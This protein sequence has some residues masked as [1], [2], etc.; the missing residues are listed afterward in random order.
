MAQANTPFLRWKDRFHRGKFAKKSK[1]RLFLLRPTF[2]KLR[3]VSKAKPDEKNPPATEVEIL[4]FIR[5]VMTSFDEP[6]EW[7]VKRGFLTQNQEKEITA[8][9]ISNP[10]KR[11]GLTVL[12]PK[13]EEFVGE[14]DGGHVPLIMEYE[15]GLPN[16]WIDSDDLPQSIEL[17]QLPIKHLK[18]VY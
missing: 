15:D 3:R 17:H 13:A 7:Y 8:A 18:A 9:Y 6:R 5:D 2:D 1:F 4:R 16:R 12:F 14:L 11:G 10:E